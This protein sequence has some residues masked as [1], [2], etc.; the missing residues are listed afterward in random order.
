LGG[1]SIGKVMDD[2]NLIIIQHLAALKDHLTYQHGMN[3]ASL[4]KTAM[5]LEQLPYCLAASY[6]ATISLMNRAQSIAAWHDKDVG[7]T[8]LSLWLDQGEKDSLAFSIDTFLES[9]VRTQNAL[10]PYLGSSLS[11]SMPSSL[12]DVMSKLTKDKLKLPAPI[13]EQL[14]KYWNGCGKRLRAYRDLSQHF[15]LVSS[16]G[17][18]KRDASGML[19]LYLT[20]PNNPEVKNISQL[21]FVDP[22]V[23]ALPYVLNELIKVIAVVYR[24]TDLLLPLGIDRSS[25]FFTLIPRDEA[26]SSIRSGINIPEPGVV[27]HEVA[28]CIKRQDVWREKRREIKQ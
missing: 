1:I 13:A 10:I 2:T 23:H 19:F 16:E 15:A 17:T 5:S 3:S 4:R 9:A 22:I 18:L 6:A 7:T 20:I 21:S 28:E 11:M 25:Q 26:M 27:E 24:I 14:T 12:R 8:G